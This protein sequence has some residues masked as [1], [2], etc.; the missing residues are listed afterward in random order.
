MRSQRDP[1]PDCGLRLILGV[2]LPAAP[3]IL[4]VGPLVGL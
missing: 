4:A 1:D 2:A 3:V